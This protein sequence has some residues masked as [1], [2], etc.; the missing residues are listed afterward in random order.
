LPPTSV[1][2]LVLAASWLLNP[3][4][5]V[6]VVPAVQVASQLFETWLTGR[7]GGEVGKVGPG[8]GVMVEPPVEPVVVVPPE[9][10]VVVPPLEPVVVVPPELVVVVPPLEPVVVVPP[11]LV[12]VVPPLEPVTVPP[13][14]EIVAGAAIAV[15][16]R[17]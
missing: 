3:G 15:L 10:V 8:L 11:E 17:L 7:E 16:L 1:T 6:S 12:V 14:V 13:L 4:T 2:L 9:L 5:A